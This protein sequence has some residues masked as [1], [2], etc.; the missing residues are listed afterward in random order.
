[1]SRKLILR[2]ILPIATAFVL[3]Q[4]TLAKPPPKQPL[5]VEQ[6]QQVKPKEKK[7]VETLKRFVETF[8]QAAKTEYLALMAEISGNTKPFH[9]F[10]KNLKEDTRLYAIYT[11][12]KAE[13]AEEF[14]RIIEN[15]HTTMLRAV[16]SIFNDWA[17]EHSSFEGVKSYFVKL[18]KGERPEEST[19]PPIIV[20][21]SYFDAQ[22]WKSLKQKYGLDNTYWLEE[23]I[24]ERI[25]RKISELEKAKQ[26]E[27]REDVLVK[28]KF[29]ETGMNVGRLT[30]ELRQH[31]G[32]E[33]L[34][35]L[36]ELTRHQVG[37]GNLLEILVFM[38][39]NSIIEK[40]GWKEKHE[41]WKAEQER[42]R[43]E[44]ERAH[45]NRIIVYVVGACLFIA[46]MF[47][48][49][50]WLRKR[51]ERMKMREK[52]LQE[53][54]RE[55]EL[56][57]SDLW[58]KLKKAKTEDEVKKIRAEKSAIYDEINK[59]YSKK[60]A[61]GIMDGIRIAGINFTQSYTVHLSRV[62]GGIRKPWHISL[63]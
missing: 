35:Q 57:I 31:K 18:S 63:R 58:H 55:Y 12:I 36:K 19:P 24:K 1:M 27:Q 17:K 60:D 48:M 39:E 26:K 29:G 21:P 7:A 33:K 62:T 44:E 2:L 4:P 16:E 9:L 11:S 37:D 22:L 41:D 25:D 56:R 3:L 49:K 54:V 20:S 15:I 42:L 28:K 47:V 38:E 23:F 59:R 50:F 53:I 8:D 5:Q 61:R 34:K 40:Q 13:N 45:R 14:C 30:R 10:M 32:E 6:I 46:S 52:E 51:R 43:Q